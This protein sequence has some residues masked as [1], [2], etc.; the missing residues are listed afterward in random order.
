[1]TVAGLLNQIDAKELMEWRAFYNIEPF[2]EER[3]DLRMAM[4]CCTLANIHRG[5]NTPPYR[6]SDFLLRF[7]PKPQQTEEEMKA[8][9]KSI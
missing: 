2:G 4:V 5:K 3:E 8:I 6:L 1:M 7:D 9:L